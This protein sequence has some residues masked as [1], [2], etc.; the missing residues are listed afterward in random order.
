LLLSNRFITGNEAHPN[1]LEENLIKEL[2][3][4]VEQGV[5]ES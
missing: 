1:L 4:K 5:E 2:F 3:M